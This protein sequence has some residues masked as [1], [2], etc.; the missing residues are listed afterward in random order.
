MVSGTR[1]DELREPTSVGRP[2]ELAAVDHHAADGGA[3]AAYPFGRTVHDDIRSVFDGSAEEP[4]GCEGVIDDHGDAV[5]VGDVG[6]GREVGHCVPRVPDCF[7][8]DGLGAVVD[9]GGQGLRV[10]GG[11]ELG[12]DAQTR[13]QDF[14]LVVGAAVQVT[15][16]DDVV[17]RVCQGC[18]GH[19]LG[20]LAG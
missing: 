10:I 4:A 2:V 3:V 15:R 17:A 19:E 13:Q 7:D 12:G 9:C 6:Q 18:D 14:E 20:R 11:Q 8:V 1:L 5:R 16:R